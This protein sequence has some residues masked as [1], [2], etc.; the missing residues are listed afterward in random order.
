M[1]LSRVQCTVLPILIAAAVVVMSAKSFDQEQRTGDS[2]LPTR[3][4]TKGEH[5]KVEPSKHQEVTRRPDVIRFRVVDAD[6]GKPV[7]LARIVIDNGNLAPDL[8]EDSDAV[9]WPDG[10]AILV[11]KRT[12]GFLQYRQPRRCTKIYEKRAIFST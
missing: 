1:K 4:S 9:T 3:P 11:R 12:P 10:R 7:S 2:R 8:G 6:T 5:A